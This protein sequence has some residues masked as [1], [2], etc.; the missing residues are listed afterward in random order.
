MCRR[1]DLAT[2]SHITH[3]IDIIACHLVV[4]RA[5]TVPVNHL[6][7]HPYHMYVYVVCVVHSGLKI[8]NTLIYSN[9][10]QIHFF[11]FLHSTSII[12]VVEIQKIVRFELILRNLHFVVCWDVI[13]FV[14]LL[15][16][17]M[18]GLFV[19]NKIIIVNDCL[20]KSIGTLVCLLL[21]GYWAI[22]RMYELQL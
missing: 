2:S 19:Y 7:S 15:W 5:C 12:F 1:A 17:K 18:W 11:R 3:F 21:H 22:W 9:K 14:V 20:W 8:E 6:H 16:C 10:I 13:K 4:H